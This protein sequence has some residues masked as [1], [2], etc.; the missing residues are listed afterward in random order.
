VPTSTSCTVDPAAL[1]LCQ[2]L[3][4]RGLLADVRVLFVCGAPDA[5]VVACRQAGDVT[6]EVL[7]SLAGDRPD[8]HWH[9]VRVSGVERSVWRGPHRGAPTASVTGFVESLLADAA[10]RLPY[11]RIG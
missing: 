1:I 10:D 7:A 5:R 3:R 6:V 2:T 8:D 11:S 4:D 9:A